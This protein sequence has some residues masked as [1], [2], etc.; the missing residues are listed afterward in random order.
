MQTDLLREARRRCAGRYLLGPPDLV[1][2]LDVLAALRDTQTLLTDLVERPEWVKDRLQE[3]NRAD[4]SIF[5]RIL[6][7]VRDESGGNAFCFH[8]YGDGKTA[9]VQ[10]DIACMLSPAMFR[11]FVVGPLAEQCRYLDYSM[12]H[13]DGEDAPR[14]LGPGRG[15][16]GADMSANAA[17]RPSA[18]PPCASKPARRNASHV[19]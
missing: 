14:R 2:N 10:C 1:G 7:L 8:L 3:I 9:K 11:E 19:P 12:F 16:R 13:L 18:R 4:F 5:E 15:P 6:E 17:G